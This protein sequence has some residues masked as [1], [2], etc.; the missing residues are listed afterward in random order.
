MSDDELIG[1]QEFIHQDNQGEHHV[2][3]AEVP[4]PPPLTP[5]SV[6]V[7]PE[8]KPDQIER[9]ATLMARRDRELIE[10]L[11]KLQRP[12]P[13]PPPKQE[14][15]IDP[16]T[17]WTIPDDIPPGPESSRYLHRQMESYVNHRISA[18]EQK[19]RDLELAAVYQG[20]AMQVNPEFLAVK[21][22]AVKI[23]NSGIVNSFDVAIELAKA[24]VERQ[25]ASQGT[26]PVPP[27]RAPRT[28]PK[29]P[30][31]PPTASAPSTTSGQAYTPQRVRG[32]NASYS[33]RIK[34][35]P[36]LFNM[37]LAAGKKDGG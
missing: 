18:Y 21:D 5:P 1:E 31:P 35:K 15:P 27:G 19:L 8:E 22:E 7:P 4:P 6:E 23:F 9:L 28:A 3:E 16:A 32:Q 20:H 14:D 36:E 10:R 13:P 2:P 26:G 30:T 11:E 37:F 34:A 12:T 33:D 25:V 24:R 29:A 17:F